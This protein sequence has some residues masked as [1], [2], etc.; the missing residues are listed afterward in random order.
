MKL[1]I[2]FESQQRVCAHLYSLIVKNKNISPKPYIIG[3]IDD[4]YSLGWYCDLCVKRYSLPKNGIFLFD[5]PESKEDYDNLVWLEKLNNLDDFS[6]FVK[7]IGGLEIVDDKGHN[8]FS[9]F[10]LDK[11]SN[12]VDF[13]AFESCSGI[14]KVDIDIIVNNTQMI[15]YGTNRK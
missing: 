15:P 7:K 5:F 2:N 9:P 13:S 1:K 10:S 12:Y 3:L 11:I 8:P 6:V 4:S 14:S